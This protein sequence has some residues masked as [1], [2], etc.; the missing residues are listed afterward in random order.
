MQQYYFKTDTAGNITGHTDP[1]FAGNQAGGILMAPDPAWKPDDNSSWKIIDRDG[2]KVMV[3]R[4]TGLT[5]LQETQLVTKQLT[6]GSANG[7]IND[8]A[9]QQTLTQLVTGMAQ[10]QATITELATPA[11]K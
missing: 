5:S 3:K 10:V 1:E 11:D 7:L 8:L 4:D 9:V 6:E 2:V